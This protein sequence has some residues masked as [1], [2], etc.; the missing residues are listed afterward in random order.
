MPNFRKAM[1][2]LST[3]FRFSPSE[4]TTTRLTMATGSWS[5]CPGRLLFVP[6]SR[7]WQ[8]SPRAALVVYLPQRGRRRRANRQS[9]VVLSLQECRVGISSSGA[10]DDD[11][12]LSLA[13]SL[14]DG[15][16]A[17]PRP[18]FPFIHP[19]RTASPPPPLLPPRLA[20]PRPVGLS[21]AQLSSAQLLL[22]SSPSAVL[23]LLLPPLLLFHVAVLFEGYNSSPLLPLSL[24]LSLAGWRCKYSPI[25]QMGKRATRQAQVCERTRQRCGLWDKLLTRLHTTPLSCLVFAEGAPWTAGV[26]VAA[27]RLLRRADSPAPCTYLL[28]Q[29]KQPE[30][31][32][33][34]ESSG[35]P[36]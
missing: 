29:G 28:F 16:P 3:L 5:R 15:R 31:L 34:T 12:N 10:G 2:A 20:S 18:V 17:P 4:K 9:S 36:S 19:S 23:L 7:P 35:I 13:R 14:A 26:V 30:L 27:V 24:F 8:P 6:V 11:D 25:R 22:L 1:C 33:Q 21:S 32:I